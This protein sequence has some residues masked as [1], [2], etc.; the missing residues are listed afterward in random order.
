MEYT[1]VFG[2]IKVHFYSDRE[3]QKL[4]IQVGLTYLGSPTP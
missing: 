1:L 3:S 2:Q 4:Y